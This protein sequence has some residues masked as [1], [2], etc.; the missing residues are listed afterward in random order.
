MPQACPSH[1]ATRLDPEVELQQSVLFTPT[2]TKQL[3]SPQSR[4]RSP[5]SN[6]RALDSVHLQPR[7]TGFVSP[8]CQLAQFGVAEGR[9]STRL[10]VAEERQEERQA[11]A[12]ENCADPESP[13]GGNFPAMKENDAKCRQTKLVQVRFQ[14]PHE[15]PA[16]GESSENGQLQPSLDPKTHNLSDLSS[17]LNLLLHCP[18][19]RPATSTMTR[20][21]ASARQPCQLFGVSE[22]GQSRLED[23]WDEKRWSSTRQMDIVRTA[24]AKGATAEFGL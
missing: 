6:I 9:S 2:V 20:E 22:A 21:I 8:P 5:T 13:R 3:P 11:E 17:L 12:E 16:R 19:G 14:L 7:Q 15:T 18:H 10:P 1:M 24:N 4:L 23:D